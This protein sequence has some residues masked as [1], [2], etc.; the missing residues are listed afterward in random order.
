MQI[1][2]QKKSI[3]RTSLR[4][5]SKQAVEISTSSDTAFSALDDLAAS[6]TGGASGTPDRQEPSFFSSFAPERG[7][8]ADVSGDQDQPSSFL[9]NIGVQQYYAAPEADASKTVNKRTSADE[10][11][12]KMHGLP[13]SSN[14]IASSAEE[15]LPALAF[16]LILPFAM[17]LVVYR[18]YV[19]MRE[20]GPQEKGDNG[21]SALST[22][23]STTTNPAASTGFANELPD[24]EEL[25][26]NEADETQE[27]NFDNPLV[28][29]SPPSGHEIMQTSSLVASIENCCEQDKQELQGELDAIESII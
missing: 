26:N 22:T 8:S 9:E 12:V 24:L 28:T 7:G 4:G 1:L 16:L 25:D 14:K 21:E 18:L 17:R 13:T 10:T 20:R 29:C 3:V 5:A 6:S 27:H 11:R 2:K 19:R 15:W 23:T